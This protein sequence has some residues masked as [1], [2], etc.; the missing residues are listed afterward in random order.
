MAVATDVG[1]VRQINEDT[2]KTGET[3]VVVAD[4]MGGHAA[5][6]VA[7]QMTAETIAAVFG[8][9]PTLAGLEKS[10][11]EANRRVLIDARDNVERRGMGTTA[12]ALGLVQHDERTVPVIAHVG[13]SRAYQLRDGAIRQLTDDHS[14]AEEWVRQ[15]RLTPD[16]AKV[17]PQRHQLTRCVGIED[18]MAVDILS[19][20]A[21]PGDRILLCSDGL[22]NE[23][24]ESELAEI[25]GADADLASIVDALV[26]AANA[27]GGRDN[28]TV[29]LVEFDDVTA[30][31]PAIR[32]TGSER[33]SPESDRSTRPAPSRPTRRRTW[34]NS[35]RIWASAGALVATVVAAIM[36]LHWYTYSSVYIGNDHGVVALY[37][38]TPPG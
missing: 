8:E 2:V 16:E 14:V 38:R 24:S 6:E 9:E 15:G 33:N 10:F 32:R 22:S 20:D 25:A 29:A 4:G 35:W 34:W 5:G 31:S 28:I 7:S 27:H 13:D 17:H 36:V 21:Q 12:I 23:L 37:Q 19:V 18:P 26:A 1:S 3:L 11:A 30:L